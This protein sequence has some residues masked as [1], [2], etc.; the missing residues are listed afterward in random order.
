MGWVTGAVCVV[1]GLL[2]T[3]GLEAAERPNIVLILADDMGY[4]D[5]GCYNPASRI[6]TP[7]ID[8]LARQG[9]R[10]TDAHAPASVCVPTRYGLLT[11]RYPFRSRRSERTESRIEPGRLT[12]GGFLQQQGYRTACVGKWHQGFAGGKSRTDY[13][14]PILQG[15][16]DRGFDHF[17]GIPASLD[18]PPYYWIRD[19]RVVTA[20][21]AMAKDNFSPGWTRIQGAFWRAGPVAPDF[22]FEQ[23][24]PRVEKQAIGFID[25]WAA[26]SRG[27]SKT[28]FLL[29]VPLPA[30]HTPWLP[31]QEFRG[32]S[33]ASMYGD[34]T[35][36][37]DATVGAILGALE[38]QKIEKQTLVV[39]T[40]DNGPVWYPADTKRL[41]HNSVG[42][43]RGMKGD[44]WEAGHRMPMIVRWP[45]HVPAGT[46][47]DHLWCHTDFLATVAQITGG[48]VPAGAGDDSVGQL[49][50]WVDPRRA[51]PARRTLVTRSSGRVLAVRDG[52]W[53]YIP[54]LGS[55]GF[56]QPRKRKPRDGEPPVQL[57]DLANDIGER[58]NLAASEPARL[59]S[60]RELARK[61]TGRDSR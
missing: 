32:K 18:I 45:G 7:H 13:S 5:P 11:G 21:T 39:F 52:R 40:S 34:F 22:E 30:P 3:V 14:K 25:R 33:G 46:T 20:P 2:G 4:G 47:S 35:M 27:D 60:I 23:V 61:L 31:S 8:R 6:P 12:L 26:D 50:V 58:R 42:P 51:P 36:M 41:K 56:S 43:L 48:R 19:N 9:L 38:K 44:A 49:S 17:F 54:Q 10:L 59:K 55:G 29:Y 16:I 24:L 57:Y 15:P 28:P 37:V 53:K 1:S